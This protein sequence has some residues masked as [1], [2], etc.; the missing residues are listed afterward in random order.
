MAMKLLWSL[1]HDAGEDICVLEV[2]LSCHLPSLLDVLPEVD[3]L[4]VL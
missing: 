4:P 1:H 2:V 3:L